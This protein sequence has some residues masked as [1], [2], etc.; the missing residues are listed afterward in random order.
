MKLKCGVPLISTGK[1]TGIGG[2]TV[3][4]GPAE[5]I[6]FHKVHRIILYPFLSNTVL[7]S[8]ARLWEERVWSNSHCRL[9]P[10]TPRISS[11]VNWLSDE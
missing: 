4:A 6:N 5:E 1:Y 8:R 11:R 3:C 2:W 10:K 7:V 9:V